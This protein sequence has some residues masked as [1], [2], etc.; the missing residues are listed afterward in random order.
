MALRS[1]RTVYKVGDCFIHNSSGDILEITM[2]ADFPGYNV[3][4]YSTRW[5]KGEGIPTD[6]TNDT[7][8]RYFKFSPAASTLLGTKL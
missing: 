8:K 1:F 7:L 3:T 5:L 4:N 6:V 2:V